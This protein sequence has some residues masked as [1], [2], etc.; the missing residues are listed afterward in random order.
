MTKATTKTKE[1]QPDLLGAPQQAPAP[2]PPAKSGHGPKKKAEAST[3]VAVHKP[4]EPR[5]LLAVIAEAS[6]NPNI[7]VAKMKELLAFKREIE[8]EEKE[9]VL[10]EAIAA[11]KAELPDMVNAGSWNRHTKS[12]WARYEQVS[13]VIDPIIRKHGLVLSYGMSDSPITDHYRVFCDVTHVASG[14][15]RRYFVDGPSD[16]A[17]AKGGGT[18]SPIQGVKS[19]ITYLQRA[20]KC[21][22]FDVVVGREDRDGQGNAPEAISDEQ[23]ETIISICAEKG[24]DRA[25]FEKAFQSSVEDLPATRYKDVLARLKAAPVK[26]KASDAQDS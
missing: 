12:W 20:L 21:M 5:S 24:I 22:V 26:Q 8:R 6:A 16:A 25:T 18:K 2:K 7:D 15:K 11:V 17:G 4:A 1:A 13:K 14:G 10:D 9:R 23:A 19:T 3:A